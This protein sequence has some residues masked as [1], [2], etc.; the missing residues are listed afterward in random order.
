M[1]VLV[2]VKRS[3]LRAVLEELGESFPDMDIVVV[4]LPIAF[5]STER[6]R[7]M[8]LMLDGGFYIGSCGLT[9]GW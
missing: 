4:A 3:E 2:S 8:P 7:S 1:R 5:Y 6:Q 9:A